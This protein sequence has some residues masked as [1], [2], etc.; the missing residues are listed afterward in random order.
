MAVLPLIAMHGIVKRY[1]GITALRDVNLSVDPGE[2]MALV[3]ENGAGK[4]TLL[5]ILAGAV[6]ADEGVIKVSG[7]SVQIHSPRESQARGIADI[8]QELNLA[9]DLSVAE[10]IYVGREPRNRLGVVD[11][12]AMERGAGR[13]CP[14]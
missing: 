14:P 13:S 10:N 6:R 8:Y 12:R 3:G 4:S 5:K 9:N 7:E 2:V 11:F 1:P